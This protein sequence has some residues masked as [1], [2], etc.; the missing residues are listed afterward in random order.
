MVSLA[1]V[2]EFPAGCGNFAALIES[3]PGTY[4][5]HYSCPPP[6]LYLSRFAWINSWVSPSKHEQPFVWTYFGSQNGENLKHLIGI[7]ATVTNTVHHVEFGYSRTGIPDQCRSMGCRCSPQN[8]RDIPFSIDGPG[9][10]V[11]E[12]V[13][14]GLEVTDGLDWIKSEN[15]ASVVCF[16]VS[17]LLCYLSAVP[18]LSSAF[19]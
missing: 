11:I 19:N 2:E 9:G 8:A 18:M 6:G 13:D 12:A 16:K 5:R 15:H 4:V 1:V 14:V 3:L 10:E 17:G 7:T